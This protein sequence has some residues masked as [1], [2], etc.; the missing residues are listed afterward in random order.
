[1]ELLDKNLPSELASTAR[2]AAARA[3]HA[4][5]PFA[6]PLLDPLR[7]RRSRPAGL[8]RVVAEH[9]WAIGTAA[10]VLAGIAVVALTKSSSSAPADE[11][12]AGGPQRI[13][14]AA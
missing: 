10:V 6:E 8:R 13:R 9:P 1:M 2:D 11:A 3:V 5:E 7:S 4:I 12:A 14:S